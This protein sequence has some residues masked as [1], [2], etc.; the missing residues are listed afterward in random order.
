MTDPLTGRVLVVDDEVD[1]GVDVGD[2]VGADAD[3]VG[4]AVYAD[5]HKI[6]L[7]INK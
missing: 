6:S 5:P 2:N 7:N 3:G 4:L 1:L